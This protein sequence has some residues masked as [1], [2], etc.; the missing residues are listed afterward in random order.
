VKARLSFK[1]D[2]ATLR[3]GQTIRYSGR[4][5]GQTRRPLV[6]VQVRSQGRWVNV[7]VVRARTGGA[8]SC[9]YRFRRT[10]RPTTYTFRALVKTQEGLPYD[11]AASA[12]RRLRVRS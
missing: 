10:F 9:R 4:V 8:Y 12:S 1:L 5:D 11:T 7:C 3:N 6:Q 2:R